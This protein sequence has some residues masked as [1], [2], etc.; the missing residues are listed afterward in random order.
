LR[1]I[2][3]HDYRSAVKRYV[4]PRRD[5]EQ[6]EASQYSVDSFC[7]GDEDDIIYDDEDDGLP[8]SETH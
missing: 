2:A 8:T 5:E 4:A 7:V 6:I 1:L 3:C